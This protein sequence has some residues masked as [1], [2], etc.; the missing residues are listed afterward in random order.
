VRFSQPLLGLIL[1]QV[2]VHAAMAGIRL[3]VPLQ[4]LREGAP[5]WLVGLLL[6]LFALA[7]VVLALPAG[8]MADRHGFHRPMKLAVTMVALGGAL[9]VFDAHL[10]VL[11]VAALLAGGGSN[12]S[13]IAIQ[14]TA[15]HLA[16][17]RT[18][19]LRIFS[20]LGL[21]PAMANVVGPVLV[22]ALIDLA[23]F[24]A[25]YA[26]MAVLPWVGLAMSRLVPA[27]A[28]AGTLDVSAPPPP[29]RL[30][31]LQSA[32]ELFLRPGMRRLLLVNWLVSASWDVHAFL[33]P[34]LGHERD[35]S[36][37]AIGTVLGVFAAAVA[38]VRLLIPLVAHRLTEARSLGAAMLTTA[39]VFV[40]YPF[41]PNALWMG[42]CA[43]VL[44]M[45][46]GTVQPMIMS[47]LH[48]LTP[49][50][51][52]GEAVA[53]RSM[54]INFASTAMPLLFGV[55][56]TATGSAALFWVM[57]LSVGSGSVLLKRLAGQLKAA[58]GEGVS[59][60]EPGR[61]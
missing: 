28:R 52:H 51:R 36:A 53:L 60:R 26:A 55:V 32:R 41:A 45:A 42:A 23:G 13:L 35:L 8:R 48:R 3:A 10:A 25:A 39:C 49:P 58:G 38:G 19:R 11:A 37:S 21:A 1:A 61:D 9:A 20:W 34:V 4:A 43:V 44:G 50:D 14:R 33:V 30:P 15:G 5:E 16:R 24:R 6:A 29:P 46:L 56:G 12:V 7:P 17:D 31:V 59:T 18:E 40:A 2:C 22:G 47:S 54:T 57:A 27:D